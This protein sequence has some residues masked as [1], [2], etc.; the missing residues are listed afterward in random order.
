MAVPLSWLMTGDTFGDVGVRLE[1]DGT[2]D[3]QYNGRAIFTNVQLPNFAPIADASFVIGG[4]TGGANANQWIDDIKIV[5]TS[6]PVGPTVSIVR[7]ADSGTLTITWSGPG[8]LQSA[9]AVTGP[10]GDLQGVVSG[11]TLQATGAM[12][13]FRV[14]QPAP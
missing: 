13:F 2:V 5:T 8:T 3:V 1:A 9:P 4:R 12:Q 6:G 14:V 11:V 7:N 10:W